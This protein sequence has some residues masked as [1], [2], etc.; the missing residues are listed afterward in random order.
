MWNGA[1]TTTD[2][3]GQED[4]CSLQGARISS[5]TNVRGWL[6]EEWK[7]NRSMK[8]H[9]ENFLLCGKHQVSLCVI[10]DVLA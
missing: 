5:P 10:E 1:N 9:E 7:N 6:F 4:L 8:S 2:C 3:Y